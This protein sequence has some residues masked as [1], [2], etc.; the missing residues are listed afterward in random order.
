MASVKRSKSRFEVSTTGMRLLHDGRP[1]W[2]LVKELI[3]NV[4]DEEM[5]GICRV[6]LKSASRGLIEVTVEDDGP[7][8]RDITDAYTIFAP[9]PKQGNASVR[10]R[11]NLGEKELLSL[12]RTAAIETVG[13]TVE[14]P[15]SGGKKVKRNNKE[16]GTKVT[17]ILKGRQDEIG[18]TVEKLKTFIVPPDIK[19]TINGQSV[20]PRELIAQTEAILAT[21]LSSGINQPLRPT[22]R[23]TTIRVYNPYIDGLGHIYEMGIP[24]QSIDMPFDVDIGGKVPLPPNR[25]VVSKNY[26]QDVYAEVL[27]VTTDFVD[28]SNAADSWI[29]MA[30]ED[31][32]TNDATVKDIMLKKLG[33]KAVI[34]TL[35]RTE[36]EEAYDHGYHV[37]PGKALSTV[38]RERFYEVGL[39]TAHIFARFDPDGPPLR[40]AVVTEAMK[41]VESYTQWLSEQ[42]LGYRCR[43]E[44]VND[45][46]FKKSA[47][48]G[49]RTLRFNVFSLSKAFFEN[50]PTQEQTAL[51]LHELA[52]DKRTDVPH[53]TQY[54]REL[55]E[56]SAKAVFL[57]LALGSANWWS[58]Q[59]VYDLV[60]L[61]R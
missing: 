15:L 47:D 22:T 10:G 13:H 17:A 32:R 58:P 51:I 60:T 23:K 53:G 19:Y 31:P 28:A 1:L 34:A 39:Q 56:L 45:I 18:S 48:F 14:F 33:E 12:C 8:F 55:Q 30:V 11:F 42:L 27:A 41:Q 49:N 44:F 29:T 2:Q 36:N 21:V 16:R 46:L 59:P 54:I 9:T 35:D 43:V 6:E 40:M 38:E 4:W 24:I 37:I 7:G 52:H 5:V 20:R 57:G 61:E 25:D 26:L 50:A 3:S